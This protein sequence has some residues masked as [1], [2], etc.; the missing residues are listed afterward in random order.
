M[1]HDGLGRRREQGGPRPRILF[2]SLPAAR[3]KTVRPHQNSAWGLSEPQE[4][5][6]VYHAGPC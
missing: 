3:P 1:R 5:S 4:A 2:K 6:N